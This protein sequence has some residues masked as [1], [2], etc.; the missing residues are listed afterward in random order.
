MFL[1]WLNFLAKTFMRFHCNIMSE[2]QKKKKTNEN[3]DLLRQHIQ[4]FSNSNVIGFSFRK[5]TFD[6]KSRNKHY[7]TYCP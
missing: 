3:N 5:F 6:D 1:Y 2:K 4:I 7:Y